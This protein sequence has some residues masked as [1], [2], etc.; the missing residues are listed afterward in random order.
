MLLYS[1]IECFSAFL[2]I[3]DIFC[4]QSSYFKANKIKPECISLAVCPEIATDIHVSSCCRYSLWAFLKSTNRER[5]N[6][7][8]ETAITLQ[9]KYPR[10]HIQRK[11]ICSLY[12]IWI[13]LDNKS[14]MQAILCQSKIECIFEGDVEAPSTGSV[15]LVANSGEHHIHVPG[16]DY[17]SFYV[18]MTSSNGNVFRVTGHLCGEFTGPRWIPRTKAS[19]AE[20]CFLWSASE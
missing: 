7:S 14:P 4:S 1:K 12:W 9:R 20:L 10:L 17:W 11:H 2:Y 6:F 16:L 8:V 5:A 19:D 15:S 18:M 3:F 13:N